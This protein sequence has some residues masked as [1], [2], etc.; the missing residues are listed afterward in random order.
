MIE[1]EKIVDKLVEYG[2]L[3]VH[4]I[5]GDWYQCY[6]PFHSDGQERRP[7]FGILLHEQHRNGL[8]YRAGFGHCFTCG[9]AGNIDTI[10]EKILQTK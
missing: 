8:T 3:R 4:K 9:V 2:L 5:S 7:S 6:C 1:V 10:V